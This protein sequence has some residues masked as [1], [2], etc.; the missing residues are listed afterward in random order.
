[1]MVSSAS[2]GT[3]FFSFQRNNGIASSEE[4]G[5]SSKCWTNTRITGSGRIKA[6]SLAVVKACERLRTGPEEAALILPDP[7][8]RVFVQQFE[9]FLRPSEEAIP[10]LCWK[11]KKSEPVE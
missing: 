1:M 5:K 8:I 9:D 2:N 11:L 3:L 7:V 6:A 4:R 10:L